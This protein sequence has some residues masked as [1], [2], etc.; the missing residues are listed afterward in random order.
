MHWDGFSSVSSP[1]VNALR[2]AVK[3]QKVQ[4]LQFNAIGA[5]LAA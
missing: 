2:E 3:S 5:W 4:E 1:S